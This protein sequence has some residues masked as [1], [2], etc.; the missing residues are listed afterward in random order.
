[1]NE[2][3]IYTIEL[4]GLVANEE[5]QDG[6]DNEKQSSLSWCVNSPDHYKESS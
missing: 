1:M 5:E 6:E 3:D 2:E 4:P